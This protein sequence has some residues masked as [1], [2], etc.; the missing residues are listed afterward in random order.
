ML[1][2]HLNGDIIRHPDYKYIQEK[3]KVK[4]EARN[5]CK[6][7]IHEDS[8]QAWQNSLQNWQNVKDNNNC[9]HCMLSQSPNCP[10]RQ[11]AMEH[12]RK[13]K[14]Y[15]IG[16]TVY[17]KLS[18][19]AHYMTKVGKHRSIFVTL[20][21]P[22]FKRKVNEIEINQAFSRFMENLHNNYEVKYYLAVREYG[23]HGGRVHFH[24]LLNMRFY[25][26]TK[27]NRAW[28][29]AISD[30]CESSPN[31]LS[32]ASKKKSVILYDPRKAV[33]YICKYISKARGQISKTRIVFMSLP[34]IL[35]PIHENHRL[36]DALK[37]FKS[38]YQVQT[39]DYTTLFRITDEKEFEQFCNMYLYKLFNFPDKPTKFTGI[40]GSFN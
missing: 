4:R 35:K 3:L 33:R 19:A 21:L 5:V 32:S 2:V 28:C 1:N 27:L 18:S 36:I 10:G 34:L 16:S 39:S 22:P 20:T 24:L 17:R 38:L 11:K 37:G 13:E 14:T 26:F 25:S 9:G 30:I 29:S 8:C 15:S 31:A 6:Y 40:P 7:N 12:G 23:S